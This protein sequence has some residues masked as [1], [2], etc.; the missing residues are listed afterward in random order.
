MCI[1]IYIHALKKGI[2]IFTYITIMNMKVIV[3]VHTPSRTRGA[4]HKQ[5]AALVGELP[6]S[7]KQFQHLQILRLS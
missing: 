4:V 2:S 7:T 6:F 3:I 5:A 1:Y